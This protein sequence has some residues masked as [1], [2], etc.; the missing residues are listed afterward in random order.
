MSVESANLLQLL[1]GAATIVG[2]IVGGFWALAQLVVKQFEKRLDDRFTAQDQAR[3]EGSKLYQG[4]LD[5]LE[6]EQRKLERAHLQLMGE[7]PIHYVRREDYVRNQSV[8]E[9][10][11][12]GLALKWENWRLKGGRDA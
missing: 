12:D 5:T 11:L 4:R 8:I 10:K 3:R 1:I 9:A 2:T 6:G 7:L